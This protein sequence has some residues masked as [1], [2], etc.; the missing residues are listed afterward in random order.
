MHQPRAARR[1][2]STAVSKEG[3][4][5]LSRG[6]LKQAHTGTATRV[7]AKRADEVEGELGSIADPH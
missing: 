6:T 1:H 2:E 7:F 5:G 4:P 3:R